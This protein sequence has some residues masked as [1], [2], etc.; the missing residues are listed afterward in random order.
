MRVL[1]ATN[2]EMGLR[3]LRRRQE[4]SFFSVLP[5]ADRALAVAWW[6]VLIMRGVL[7]AVFAIAMGVMLG[8]AAVGAA[9]G[10]GAVVEVVG[11]LLLLGGAA[12]AG[13]QIGTGI[14]QLID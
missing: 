8:A 4:W 11:A 2:V 12:L 1:R 6:A 13:Y 10:V 7:P 5:R 3:R 9:T 14:T